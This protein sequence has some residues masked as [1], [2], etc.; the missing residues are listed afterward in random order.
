MRRSFILILA[1]VV[2]VPLAAEDLNCGPV[3]PDITAD[4]LW[5]ALQT[6]NLKYQG[7]EIEYT[8]LKA[9]REALENKQCPPMIILSCA[10]SRVPPE[11]IF[12]QSLGS[13][14]IVRAAGNVA[15][16]FGLASIEYSISKDWARLIVV[17]GHEN[18]GAVEEAMK[19]TDPPTPSLV[20]LVDRIR[21][22]F[23]SG[24]VS[25]KQATEANARASGAWLTA[26][27]P[28]IRKAVMD[29]KVKIIP[30]YYELKSGKVTAIE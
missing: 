10:D 16:E 5:K 22:S 18:C 24:Q 27:S 11:L 21:R 3:S 19:H 1:L 9:E 20:A 29:G 14:F 30:A 25:L 12:N 7:G 6:G 15:D 26:A 28:V 13:L 4:V 23:V 17:L 8:H 2:C